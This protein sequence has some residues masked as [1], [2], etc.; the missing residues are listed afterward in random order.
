MNFSEIISWPIRF[1]LFLITF[2]IRFLG[3][4]FNWGIL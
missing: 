2:P 1:V 3:V 4:D